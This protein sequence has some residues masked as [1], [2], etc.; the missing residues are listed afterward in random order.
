M[1]RAPKLSARCSTPTRGTYCDAH[2]PAPGWVS[3]PSPSRV[4]LTRAGRHAFRAAIIRPGVRCVDCGQPATVADHVIPI[5]EGGSNDP[6]TNGQPM[7]EPCH[8]IKTQAE[9]QRAQ[10]RRR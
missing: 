6:I 3:H 8:N 5:A 10:A 1:P 9:A 4:Q 7:C 2:K